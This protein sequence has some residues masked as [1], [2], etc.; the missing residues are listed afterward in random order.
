MHSQEAGAS[1]NNQPQSENI[2]LTD[3]VHGMEEETHDSVEVGSSTTDRLLSPQFRDRA[4][5]HI[6]QIGRK[7]NILDRV[8]RRRSHSQGEGFD[9]VFSNLAAKPDNEEGNT[10]ENNDVPPTYD[11]AAA[12][13]VPSY[14]GMDLSSSSMY[15]DEICI[16]G[17]PVGNIANL[18]WNIIVSASFQFVGFLITYILHTSHAA[19]QGSRFGLGITFLGYAYSMIPNNVT[20]KVGK[21]K[22]L[23]RVELSDPN[24]F[25]DIHLYSNP[26]TQDEFESNLSHGIDD[27]KQDLP[28]LAIFISLLGIFISIK[29]IVDYVKVKKLEAKYMAQ[30]QPQEV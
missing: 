24:S 22:T 14:Y 25:D 19:K 5:R 4:A 17:L 3:N 16:E 20:S 1:S 7:F 2:E 13:M 21:H 26:S 30:E 18:L 9:G 28:I 23:N 11:E 8:F 29:S 15:Y 6:D 12:D 10:N 27:E